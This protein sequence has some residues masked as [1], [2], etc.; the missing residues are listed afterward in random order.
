GEKG[1][2]TNYIT[3]TQAVKKLQIS[4]AAFRRLCILKG[5][6]PREPKNK[7]KVGKGS[8]KP[9]TYYY[10]KDIQFLLHEPVLDKLREQKTFAKKITKALAKKEYALAKSLEENRPVY[11][12]DHIIKERY[13]S[14]IDALRDLDDALS[15]IFLFATL[16]TDDK[17]ASTHI[18]TC[19]RLSAEF[20]NY[21]VI[22][23]SLRKVF[24]SIKGIYY[25]AE[26]KG[27][28]VTWIVPYQFS[29]QV[30][31][32][33]DFRVMQTF[34][35]LY[36]TLIGF[37][38]Y[39]L[40]TE[41]NLVYPPK[42]DEQRDAS[43][44]G[45]SAYVLESKKSGDVLGDLAK[46]DEP[47][48]VNKAQKKETEKRLKSLAKKL[49]AMDDSADASTADA[50]PVA[51]ANDEDAMDQDVPQAAVPASTEEESVPTLDAWVAQ[52][53]SLSALQNLF[54]G[55]VFFLSREVPRYS[56]EFVILAMGGE[57]GWASSSG[58]G[59]PF[60]ENDPRIT[61][62][63]VD[64]PPVGIANG[65]ANGKAVVSTQ[66]FERREY[67]QPQWVYDSINAG[68][69]LKTSGYHPGEQLPPHVSPFVQ[70]KEGDYVPEVEDVEMTEMGLG[71]DAEAEEDDVDEAVEEEEGE[72]EEDEEEE[73]E[74]ESEEALH[75]A[76]LEAEAA[77]LSFSE[78]LEKQ[79]TTAKKGKKTESGAPKPKLT[80]A[81]AEEKEALELAKMMMNKKDRHLYNK[82]QFGKKRKEE[83][84]NKLKQKKATLLKQQKQPQARKGKSS[85]P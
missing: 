59:S 14:F 75:K 66:R 35:E 53:S 54:K 73:L 36:E 40:Y 64:R 17:I 44:V 5:I 32:N 45:L 74:S 3:R 19:Q 7:K 34:L 33:V 27:Q 49:S 26:I 43:A 72:E 2:V 81:Q 82:I 15:M 58:G 39:K 31:R 71:A 4:L 67:L 80:A 62:Q 29:Q 69:L 38:N 23:H 11:T 77:G 47:V 51:A 8:T 68:K 37:V 50:E 76:E 9:Q 24:L 42:L 83:A 48:A 30:P 20:Q 18:R 10:R 65:S 28:S 56:L 63:I 85:K 21:V 1:A 60:E 57:V 25:Q 6:Y 79:K 61:H 41:L 16:P 12:L 22:S 55:C 52:A 84:V 78:Y 13:P 70:P 46:K